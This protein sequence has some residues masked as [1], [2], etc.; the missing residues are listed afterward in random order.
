MQRKALQ[1]PAGRRHC[2]QG[3]ARQWQLLYLYPVDTF[4]IT[5]RKAGSSVAEWK[6]EV[7]SVRLPVTAVSGPARWRSLKHCVGGRGVAEGHNIITLTSYFWPDTG[8]RP[9]RN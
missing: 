3:P 1:L 5:K 4:A 9:R 7:L 6:D 2:G 8:L